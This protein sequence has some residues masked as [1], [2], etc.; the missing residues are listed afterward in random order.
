MILYPRTLNC[1]KIFIEIERTLITLKLE[2]IIDAAE[3]REIKIAIAAKMLML[4]F[5]TKDICGLWHLIFYN[6]YRKTI[7]RAR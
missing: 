1:S 4:E 7:S 5:K 6:L 3:G 2:E